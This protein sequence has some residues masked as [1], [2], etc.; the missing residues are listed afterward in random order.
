MTDSYAP[1]NRALVEQLAR[2]TTRAVDQIKR[3]SYETGCIV[4]VGYK[5]I[6]A[7]RYINDSAYYSRNWPEETFCGCRL[8]TVKEESHFHVTPKGEFLRS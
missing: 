6:M 1:D 4:Y 8:F 2:D 5:E 7:I 3:D